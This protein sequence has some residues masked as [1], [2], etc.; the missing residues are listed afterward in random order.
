MDGF[1]VFR[2]TPTSAISKAAGVAEG[3]LF[4]Y[5]KTKDDLVNA[6]YRAIKFEIA[7]ATLGVMAQE[8]LT[9]KTTHKTDKSNK[10]NKSNKTKVDHCGNGFEVFWNGVSK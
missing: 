5:F 3:T 9:H 10:S 2:A 1:R 7:E 6:L 8:P 4:T